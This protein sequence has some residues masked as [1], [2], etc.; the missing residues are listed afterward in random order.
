MVA[1]QLL[2]FGCCFLDL[3]KI[4]H[5][6]HMLFSSRFFSMHFVIVQLVYPYS[7]IDT[8]IAWKESHFIWSEISDFHKIDNVSTE[9]HAFARHILTLLSVDEILIPRYGKWSTNFSDWPLKV[10]MVPYC[11]K[12]INSVLFAFTLRLNSR[13]VCSSLWLGV[14]LSWYIREE[15]KVI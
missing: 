4:A 1:V 8:A 2:F 10:E 3:W 7:S 14:W 15:L 9:V 6:I 11:L 5:N 12:D 13:V